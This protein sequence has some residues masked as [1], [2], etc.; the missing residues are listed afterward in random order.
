[1]RPTA[2]RW[3]DWAARLAIGFLA[4]IGFFC[5]IGRPIVAALHPLLV[6][7]QIVRRITA[8]DGQATVLVEQTRI[9][10]GAAPTTRVLLKLAGREPWSIYESRGSKNIPTLAWLDRDTLLVGLACARF[11]HV[12]DPDEWT[13]ATQNARRHAVRFYYI[14]P[15][16]IF[17]G[18]KPDPLPKAPNP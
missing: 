17:P 3:I 8:P 18:P 9:G 14:D 2:P 13:H 15:K 7:A 11:D 1:M 6:E 12:A 4:V 5:L 16:C 10:G